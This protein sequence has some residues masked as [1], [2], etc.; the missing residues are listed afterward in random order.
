M[1]FQ[2]FL[3]YLLRDV[4]LTILEC[5]GWLDAMKSQYLSP[6]TDTRETPLRLL[7]K[8]FPDLAKKAFDRCLQTN[9]QSQAKQ[10]RKQTGQQVTIKNLMWTATLSNAFLAINFSFIIS[11]CN[12]FTNY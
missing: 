6:V 2:Y 11:S 5:D 3:H 12:F 10:E 8:Q 4:A 7:V 1:N 9:L